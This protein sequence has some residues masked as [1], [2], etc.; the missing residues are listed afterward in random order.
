MCLLTD[1]LLM[2]LVAF[3]LLPYLSRVCEGLADEATKRRNHH[4]PH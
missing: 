4:D 2:L 1:I 3:I